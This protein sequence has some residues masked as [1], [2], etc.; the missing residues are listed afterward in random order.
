MPSGGR[1]P[2]AGRKAGAKSRPK[3]ELER[4]RAFAAMRKQAAQARRQARDDAAQARQ[5]KRTAKA[6]TV[7]VQILAPLDTPGPPAGLGPLRFLEALMDDPSLP[8][9]FRKDCAATALPYRAAKPLL[10][11]KEQRR[12]AAWLDGDD[13]DDDGLARALRN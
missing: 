3:P 12:E 2:G 7:A 1:R 9:G 8:I 6:Q 13:D 11:L 5:A 10:G 4:E